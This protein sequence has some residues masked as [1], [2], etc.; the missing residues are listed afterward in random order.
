MSWDLSS[1]SWFDGDT[2]WVPQKSRFISPT[3]ID[4]AGDASIGA[5]IGPGGIRYKVNSRVIVGI[6]LKVD[7]IVAA[8]NNVKRTALLVSIKT[9]SIG[10]GIPR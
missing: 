7:W 1:P 6:L 4:S 5:A 3:G 8:F 10:H 2:S 9:L